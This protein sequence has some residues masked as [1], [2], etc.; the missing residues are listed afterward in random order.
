VS[1][2]LRTFHQS[3]KEFERAVY[4]EELYQA[5]VSQAKEKRDRRPFKEKIVSISP[6]KR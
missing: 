4:Y 1:D 5:A 2:L 6:L 3:S